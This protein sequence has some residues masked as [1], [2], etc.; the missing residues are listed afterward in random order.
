MSHFITCQAEAEDWFLVGQCEGRELV[1]GEEGGPLFPVIVTKEIERL[2]GKGRGK[3]I[4]IS[5]LLRVHVI[6][7]YR[8][9][10]LDRT[11]VS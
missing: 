6:D 2:C 1:Q 5:T 10:G 9:P 11:V 7:C 4:I 3:G 8:F